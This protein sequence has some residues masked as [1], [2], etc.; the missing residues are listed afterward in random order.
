MNLQEKMSR[1]FANFWNIDL[2][3][4]CIAAVFLFGLGVGWQKMSARV[5]AVEFKT[6]TNHQAAMTAIDNTKAER[7]LKI[8]TLS[9][10]IGATENELHL[11]GDLKVQVAV[12]ASQMT[13]I[14]AQLSGLRADLKEQAAAR[15]TARQD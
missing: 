2:G 14:N 6:E 15:L 3:H 13:S 8:E 4:I 12:I 11:V 10:R 7:N 1:T 5:D 9:A